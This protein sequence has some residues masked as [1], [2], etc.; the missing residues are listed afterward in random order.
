[1]ETF[2]VEVIISLFVYRKRIYILG[3]QLRVAKVIFTVYALCTVKGSK[4]ALD[5]TDNRELHNSKEI[6]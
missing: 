2:N 1:M 5:N 6:I 4:V 3:K